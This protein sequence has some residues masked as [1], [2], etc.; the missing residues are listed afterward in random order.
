[1]CGI[2]GY[3]GKR[4]VKEVLLQSLK[5]LEYRGYDSAGVCIFDGHHFQRVRSQGNID[6]LNFKL[7]EHR[8]AGPV[9]IGHT[10]WATHGVPSE[11]NAHPHMVKGIAVVHNGIMEN[12][13]EIRAELIEKKCQIH[14]ETDSELIA[15]LIH[16]FIEEGKSF[17]EALIKVNQRLTGS[18]SLLCVWDKKPKQIFAIKQ[19][20]PLILGLGEEELFVSSDLQA[21]LPYTSQVIRLMDRELIE[22][23]M[24]GK[25][26]AFSEEGKK[27]KKE[28]KKRIQKIQANSLQAEKGG[29]PHF[30]L[31]EIMEQPKV[32]A[33][34]ISSYIDQDTQQV[35]MNLKIP[36]KI[37]QILII[38]C[39][40]SYYAGKLGEYLIE[41]ET[42]FPV[43][44]EIASEFRYKRQN[45]PTG[46]LL[47]F[48]SQSGETADTLAAMDKVK[49]QKNIVTLS[50]CNVPNSSLDLKA[51][52]S[53]YMH[54]GIE[55]GVASTKAFLSTT[56]LLKLLALY[57]SSAQKQKN[58][59]N[60][61]ITYL[62][63]FILDLRSLPSQIEK[64]LSYS[65]TLKKV[66]MDLQFFKGFLYMGRGWSYPIALEGALKLKELAYVHAEGY[67]AGEIK[68]GPLALVD[69]KMV[70]IALAPKDEYYIKT[71]NNIEEVMAR[72]GALVAIGAE[73]DFELKQKSRHYFGIP[74]TDKSLYPSLCTILI[75]LLAYHFANSM[76]Y[77]VDQ[78]RNLAKSVTVE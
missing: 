39:G 73:D 24:H 26:T 18:Y 64:V 62:K 57:L 32:I 75:Q 51:Q 56:V 41:S 1:M 8:F 70:L 17:H 47:I 21:L 63:R 65:E 7:K 38:A 31:K 27:V 68:H 29:Y 13:R 48:I 36:T 42:D 59:T 40:S 9:G 12:F 78:P 25:F 58:Q 2:I 22:I 54:A 61:D 33:S 76:G 49:G 20:P 43:K 53:L 34:L 60:H 66:A 45:I 3:I 44:T 37:K 72:G 4:N 52:N 69:H 16:L 30:M 77:N 71:V 46:T 19:G 35:K 11:R 10:R 6:N 15:H 50:I 67:A 28:F 23:K 55:I 5:R 14:S 74:A